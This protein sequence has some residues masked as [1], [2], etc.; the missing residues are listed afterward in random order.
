MINSLHGRKCRHT[1]SKTDQ[2]T[3]NMANHI[4]NSLHPLVRIAY[5]QLDFMD[6]PGIKA[7]A[8]EC[9]PTSDFTEEWYCEV[10]T[11]KG[12]YA[13]GAFD[14]ET[15]EMVGMIMGETQCV[16]DAEDDVGDPILGG[17]ITAGKD[18]MVYIPI[19]GKSLTI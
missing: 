17:S 16:L 9:F 18:N 1:Y 13:H 5:R 15:G 10:L 14:Q 8:D 4:S 7:V 6:L 12:S 3:V 11:G 2:K 19:F